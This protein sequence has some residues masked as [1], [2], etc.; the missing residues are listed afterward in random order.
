MVVKRLSL[1]GADETIKRQMTKEDQGS[2]VASL[3]EQRSLVHRILPEAIAVISKQPN[4]SARCW[5]R[6]KVACL[7][8]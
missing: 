5:A 4:R 8:R 6:V 7:R 2:P 1:H 3:K